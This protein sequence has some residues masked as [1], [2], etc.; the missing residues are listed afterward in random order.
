MGRSRVDLGIVEMIA[1]IVTRFREL[2]RLYLQGTQSE[3]E[4]MLEKA[5]IRLYAEILIHLAHAVGFFREKSIGELHFF[6]LL[7]FF[8]EI[9]RSR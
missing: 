6:Y 1:R 2:E 8:W 9:W 4:L 3:L 5:L 7:M